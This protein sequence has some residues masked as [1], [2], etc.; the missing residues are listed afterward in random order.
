MKAG[1]NAQ[2]PTQEFPENY[3]RIT[4][5]LYRKKKLFG[6]LSYED[7]TFQ[8]RNSTPAKPE[9][10]FTSTAELSGV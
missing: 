9:N 5:L 4:Y 7:E 6:C 8:H 3:K 2:S 1:S 10:L